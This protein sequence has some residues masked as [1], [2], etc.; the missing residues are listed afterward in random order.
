MLDADGRQIVLL[1]TIAGKTAMSSR[2]GRRGFTLIEVL[3]AM[4]VMAIMSLMA[5]QGVDGIARTRESNQVRLE[6]V[7]RLETVIAQWEQDL[8]SIQE[9]SAVPTISCDGQSVAPRPPRARAA[10]RWS[11][12]HCVRTSRRARSGSAGPGR[13]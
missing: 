10:C 9:T 2:A 11:S 3:V 13:S 1:S 5:W 12:G 6:Q 8:A 7:L 4:V